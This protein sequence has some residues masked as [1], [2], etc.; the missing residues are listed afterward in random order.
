VAVALGIADL[1]VG[2]DTAGS[3]RVPAAL[4]GIV[5]VKPTVGLVSTDGVVPASRSYDCV[6]VFAATLSAAQAAAGLMAGSSP[7]RAWPAGAPLAAPPDVVVAVPAEG[8]LPGLDPS[9]EARFEEVVAELAE[10]ARIRR[11]DPEPFLEGGRLLYGSTLVAERYEA[12]GAFVDEHPDEVDPTVGAIVAA[13]R[14]GA[15]HELA[16]DFARVE[17]LRLRA[18]EALG[19]AHALLLPTAPFHPTLAAVA[20]DPVEPNKRLGAYCS[21]A[22][23]FDLCAVAIPAGQAGGGPFGVTVFARAFHD[24]VAADVAR[25]VAGE[26]PPESLPAGPPAIPLLVLGAHMSG[27]PLVRE[28]H[29][30]G[31]RFWRTAVTA[32][33]YRM[34][35]LPTAPPKPGLLHVGEGG[36]SL[37]GELWHLPPAGLATLLAALPAPLTLGSV[38]LADGSLV[39][40]F[41]CQASAAEGAP[42]ISGFGG[43]RGYLEAAG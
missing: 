12:V 5:G 38:E 15:A 19:E 26:L 18:L 43:W 6:T 20:A 9:W 33:A 41:L 14:S 13:A 37:A 17:R 30:R 8:S 34:Y 23:P 11:V 35:A 25:F 27:Q 22:N 1:G 29:D 32:P 2:T 3:G 21:F 40:G 36:A 24:S 39:T 42:D 7:G 16:R 10:H 28:L 4:N 31:A